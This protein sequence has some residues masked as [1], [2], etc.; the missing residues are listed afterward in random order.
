ML[1]NFLQD[2]TDIRSDEEEAISE[3]ID[4]FSNAVNHNSKSSKYINGKAKNGVH[5]NGTTSV[6]N[7][8][9]HS[10]G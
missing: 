5:L 3:D 4:E 8:S 6:M 1:L 2:I 10:I 7:G 9:A